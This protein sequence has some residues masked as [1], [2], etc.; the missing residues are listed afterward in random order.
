MQF[1]DYHDEA[2]LKTDSDTP[3]PAEGRMDV[4]E[5]VTNFMMTRS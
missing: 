3:P 4:G 5:W 2:P 1:N